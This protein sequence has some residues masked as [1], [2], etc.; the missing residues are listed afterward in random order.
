MDIEHASAVSSDSFIKYVD[1]RGTAVCPEQQYQG[2]QIAKGSK[3][4]EWC[5]MIVRHVLFFGTM[6]HPLHG[7]TGTLSIFLQNSFARLLWSM[8]LINPT[9]Q[10]PDWFS[11]IGAYKVQTTGFAYPLQTLTGWSLQLWKINATDK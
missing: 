1:D 10:N 7:S 8:S 5:S 3:F 4:H 11:H 9:T 2:H 6:L